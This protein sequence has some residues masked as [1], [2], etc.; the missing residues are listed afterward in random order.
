M[1]LSNPYY[2]ELIRKK[3]KKRYNIVMKY[4]SEFKIINFF[5]F[6]NHKLK[7]QKIH[8]K[9]EWKAKME[10]KSHGNVSKA[11]SVTS[12]GQTLQDCYFFHKRLMVKY[13]KDYTQ[14][15][16]RFKICMAELRHSCCTACT[17]S[18]FTYRL[19]C[20]FDPLCLF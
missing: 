17:M 5:L 10:S 18:M 4:S 20:M 12:Q 8:I 15:S 14:W 7:T 2:K 16:K 19:N 13:K 6:Q 1:I 9:A 3:K 11:N